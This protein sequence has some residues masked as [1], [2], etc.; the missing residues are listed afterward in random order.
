[1]AEPA[2]VVGA[3]VAIVAVAPVAIVAVAPVAIVVVA[4]VAHEGARMGAS[5]GARMAAANMAA[6]TALGCGVD[7]CQSF[8]TQKK[9]EL[10][11]S[12]S[13]PIAVGGVGLSYLRH[14]S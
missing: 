7:W 5:T 6:A 13:T 2:V 4:P 8:K 14:G 12:R 11:H 1:L 9:K 10:I 3:T